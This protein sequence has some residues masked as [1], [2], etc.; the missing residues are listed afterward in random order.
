MIQKKELRNSGKNQVMEE[1]ER[2]SIRKGVIFITSLIKK[3]VDIL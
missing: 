2:G 3:L 1:K